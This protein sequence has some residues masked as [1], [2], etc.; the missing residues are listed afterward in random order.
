MNM[1]P[2]NRRQ[3]GA[4]LVSTLLAVAASLGILAGSVS[5]YQVVRDRNITADTASGITMFR[6][7]LLTSTSA[8]G[9]GGAFADRFSGLTLRG[10]NGSG[11]ELHHAWASSVTFGVLPDGNVAFTLNGLSPKHCAALVTNF[12]SL[13]V[14]ERLQTWI[15]VND[16]WLAE[17]GEAASAAIDCSEGGSVGVV[18]AYD[19][20]GGRANTGGEQGSGAGGEQGSGESETA[21]PPEPEIEFPSGGIEVP[22]ETGSNT[23]AEGSGSN[24]PGGSSG[25]STGNPPPS[26]VT[27]LSD[28]YLS[29]AIWPH[30]WGSSPGWGGPVVS[31][32]MQTNDGD[33][34]EGG[35]S[36]RIWGDGNPTL[37]LED[38]T[39]ASEGAVGRWGT[40]ISVAPPPCGGS[41]QIYIEL[42]NGKTYG[43]SISRPDWPS[44]WGPRPAE[45][46]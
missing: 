28:A 10:F 18:I 19:G 8:K 17:D 32:W 2:N 16:S 39:R 24:T 5:Y 45:C 46:D 25:G 41:S 4:G 26:S 35:V 6:S 36:F 37:Q 14:S 40:N 7:A 22:G 9:H 12:N 3:H 34:L 13:L 44:N 11:E 20:S 30:G 21:P 1:V 42:D 15:N 23:G 43:M 29:Q 33:L 31:Q 38:G 27:H